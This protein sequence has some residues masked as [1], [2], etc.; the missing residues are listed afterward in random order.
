MRVAKLS[1]IR[2]NALLTSPGW[3]FMINSLV[4]TVYVIT[5]VVMAIFMIKS[6][7]DEDKNKCKNL[8]GF[9]FKGKC[10]KEG[11]ILE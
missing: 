1:G 4:R 5:V 9:Y 6:C 2:M 11:R 3:E 7:V 10:V 8:D